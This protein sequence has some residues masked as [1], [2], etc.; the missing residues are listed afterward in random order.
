MFSLSVNRSAYRV[1]L[2][3][4]VLL[5][6]SILAMTMLRSAFAQ[7]TQVSGAIEYAENGT[8][9]VVVFTATDPENMG[10]VVW[11]LVDGADADDFKIDKSGGVL[12]FRKSPDYEM[13]TGG[14]VGG[15]ANTYSVTVIAT[16]A[17]GIM[18]QKTVAIEVTNV[19]EA[20]KVSLDKVAPY[21]GIPLTA[22]LSDPDVVLSG[23]EW[24]WSRSTSKNGSYA[25]IVGA[26]AATYPPTSGGAS[27]DVDYYLRASVSYKDGEGD[28]KSAMA[29]SAN[30]VQ[31]KNVPNDTPAFLDLAPVTR[32]V[33]ENADAGAN[34]GAPVA[35][36]DNDGDR[37]T[38]TLGGNDNESFEI[39]QATG[40][41]TVG[42]D[43]DVDFEMK[44][45][46][47]VTVTA[48]DPAG[49][50]API[51]VTIDVSDDPN[52]PPAI[53]GDV[54]PSFDEGTDA[55]PLPG[56]QLL[57]VTFTA[58]DLD[59]PDDMIITWS[60]SGPD[61]GDFTIEG[62]ALTFRES[63]NYENP[64]DADGDNVYEVKVAATDADSNRGEKS[65]EVKVANV[66][67]PGTVTMSAVQPRVRVPLTA[68]L[69]DIDG[70][71]SDL[72]WQW[73]R[74]D[75]T[76][77]EGATSDTYT[78]TDADL[79]DATLM[80]KA[81]YTDAEG[82]GAEGAGKTATV[83]A[84]IVAADTR[85]KAPVFDDQEAERM[86]AEDAPAG[87]QLNGGAVT[88]TDPNADDV[89]TYTLRGPDA[90]SFA[91]SSADATEGQITV[92]AGTKLDF[93]TKATYMV[94]VI[95]TDSFG[96]A[97]SIDVTIKVI[98]VNE[99]PEITGPAEAKYAE[100]GTDPVAVFTATD[101]ENMGA[102]VWSLD[103][104]DAEDF[105]I[106]KSGGVLSFRKSPD[107]ETPTGGGGMVNAYSVTVIA[108][109]AGGATSLKA[110]AIE[111]TNVDEAGKVSLDK[112]AP[113]PGIPL[114]ATLS[115]P[116]VVLS[117]QEWQWSRS[118]SKNGSY[119]DIVGA[120][121]A[122]YPPTSGGASSDVDYYLR[123]SVSYKDGEGAGKSAMATSANRVQP[124]NEP[125]DTP[126]F[127]D[128]APVTRMVGENADAGA[129][130]GA[131]V[132]AADND[133]DRLTYTLGVTELFEID[134]ATGQITVGDGT[135]LD[136]DV[137]D[138]SYMVMVTATDPAGLFAT[139]DVTITVSDDE[140]EP[141]AIGEDVPASFP[142]GTDATGQQLVVVTFTATDPD[143][144]PDNRDIR[145]SLS[146]PDASDFTIT[147]GA[148]T[149]RESP[150]YENPVDAD[151]DNVYEVK[152]A[153][154]DADSNR[155]EKSV[156]VKV[157]NVDEPG[158][159]T[160]SAVQPRVGVS[161]TASLTDIDGG[162][163][164]L[165]WQWSR[166][167]TPEDTLIDGAMS[168]TYTPTAADLTDT[169]TVTATYTDA[170]GAGAEGAGKTA[171]VTTVIVAAD[172]KNKA[173]V[174]DDQEAERTIA[175]NTPG[176]RSVDG[177]AVA[178]TDPNDGDDLTYTLRGSDASSFAISSADA[179][180]GQITVGAGTKLDFE[181]KATYMV[182]VIATDSVGASASINV[183]INVTDENESPEIM[184]IGL[185]ISG[186]DSVEYAENGTDAV[187]T[188]MASGPDASMATWS[189]DGDDAGQFDI[190][191]SGELTF[192]SAPDYENPADADMDNTYMVMLSATDGT[193]T[194]TPLGVVV[195]VT[196]VVDEM[197]TVTL[198]ATQPQIGT[199][200]TADLTDDGDEILGDVTW[201]WASSNAMGGPYTD[202]EGATSAGY[203]PVAADATMYLRATAMYTDVH[204]SDEGEAV[205]E[206]MVIGL[207]ITG[208]DSVE[209]AENGTDA[210][211]T[212]M[213]SGPDASMATWSLDGDDAGQFEISSSGEL[214]FVSAPDYETAADADMDN[215]YMVMVSAT[216]GTHTATPLDVEVTVTDVVEETPIIDDGTLLDRYDRDDSG[217]IDRDEVLD[218]IDIFF[219]SDPNTDITREEV[220]DLI[221]LFFVGLES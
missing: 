139:I 97:A 204:G 26:K 68:S 72:K 83:T 212:Y 216:D 79:D 36:A 208:M 211:A 40:Q 80:V 66:D 1:L 183:T 203:T 146:G 22:T 98:D 63:P 19:D 2:V 129:N 8:D 55:S 87:V 188:Y 14:G 213:A 32:M 134:Q 34:V 39:D 18:N 15:T 69:T 189:L 29:T 120:K 112:V 21:P 88:A 177:G 196:D 160:M 206:N 116:D 92:G 103:G 49:A 61:A 180:E 190:S 30:R 152:V 27:S 46:Y 194:A 93:E 166:G 137:G 3:A 91:I 191:S 94:T 198:S 182:T 57:V 10:A 58:M 195:T 24:Q 141:P 101:P 114:T 174:F 187:A 111:V 71:V 82:A 67:E 178:A 215:T 167:E 85:N 113:Y 130:V 219:D 197:E 107:Y 59:D 9:P 43:T 73:S 110:V 135:E 172:T 109:D 185:A 209:Y 77:I 171:T 65:V 161:L 102:V 47:M 176:G 99:D 35:A 207:A 125:N 145:W 17:D 157:A 6:V 123:A 118:T 142:E 7:E 156:E 173:P 31:P 169:L 186:M 60:L 105:K 159:V 76:L 28:G 86:I 95:A 200:I 148:L 126:A 143:P 48:T 106:D 210:V 119:A 149:F 74:G 100:N 89:L 133:G 75:G 78:P 84:G 13:A 51:T 205:S 70:G 38:Y 218:A 96:V 50:S 124:F 122:T 44:K 150:N 131:P 220:L 54:P 221:D 45:V 199:E 12:S 53:T 115:D 158:T 20:G 181:T 108:T 201:Q 164:D 175:E 155:G 165:K 132:A 217:K 154:T 25:D 128:L 81:T 179:T 117:G 136:A 153:A 162:V 52:E 16:D 170:E 23:Q 11:S 33:G 138:A 168:D 202:I 184:V 192:V 5:A 42:D 56:Q 140:N 151:G 64:V 127:L 121:A 193:Y 104:V 147:G 4:G 37:L 144:D 163:S 214:T 62:G 41:I 90:S